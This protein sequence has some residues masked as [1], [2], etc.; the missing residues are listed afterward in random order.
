MPRLSLQELNHS[1]ANIPQKLLSGN[2]IHCAICFHPFSNKNSSMNLTMESISEVITILGFNCDNNKLEQQSKKVNACRICCKLFSDLTEAFAMLK[3]I[4]LHFIDLRG[5][6]GKQVILETLK[7]PVHEYDEW[8]NIIQS[9]EKE[10][11]ASQIDLKATKNLNLKQ[12]KDDAK[13]H[14]VIIFS[15]HYLTLC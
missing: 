8:K 1:V 10:F 6:V 11:P 14:K 9:I 15:T 3:E 2:E 4:K 13:L 7:R 12:P 5:K